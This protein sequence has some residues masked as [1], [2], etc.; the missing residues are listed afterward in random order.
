MNHII[1]VVYD[2]ILDRPHT[3]TRES[4][5]KTITANNRKEVETVA[6]KLNGTE[7]YI[8]SR[9]NRFTVREYRMS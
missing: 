1:Y 8:E 3:A 4:G 2:R 6:A 7:T 9:I 5:G